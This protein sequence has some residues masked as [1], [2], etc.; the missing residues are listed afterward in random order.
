MSFG[1]LLA[2][3]F[4]LL[5]WKRWYI[6]NNIKWFLVSSVVSTVC[7]AACALS[8]ALTVSAVGELRRLGFPVDLGEDTSDGRRPSP[9][10]VIAVNV[11]IAAFSELVWSLLSARVAY[12]GMMSRYTEDS[13]EGGVRGRVEV[14]TVTKGNGRRGGG[15]PPPD[16]LDHFPKTGKIAK[17]LGRREGKGC[18][19]G[20][21]SHQE[22][23][24]RV[25]GFLREQRDSDRPK[26]DA[27]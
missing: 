26:R 24:E 8:T 18:L 15:V 10:L 13:G 1:A 16:I 12:R 4:G 27:D 19:P 9:S 2:G 14:N 3:T 7:A 6:D 17:F 21:E 11:L 22:Y 25:E 20:Q 23:K 5:A